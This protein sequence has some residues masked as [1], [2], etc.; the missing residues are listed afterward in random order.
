[1]M[2]DRTQTGAAAAK[3]RRDAANSK[4]YRSRY[5]TG[6]RVYRATAFPDYAATAMER[7]GQ[8]EPGKHHTDAEIE[9]ALTRYINDADR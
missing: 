2:M 8:L 6:Q 1:M 5:N 3:R 4:R 7:A 9:A